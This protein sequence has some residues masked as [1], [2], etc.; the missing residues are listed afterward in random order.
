LQRIAIGLRPPFNKGLMFARI[1]REEGRLMPM[2]AAEMKHRLK[3][4]VKG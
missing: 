2:V 3:R 1:L 4:L